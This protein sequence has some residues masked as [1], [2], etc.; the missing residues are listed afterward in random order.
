MVSFVR[1]NLSV[2]WD[3]RFATLLDFAKAC[4]V[5]VGFGCRNGTCHTCET[6]LLSGRISYITE[7]LEPP[8]ADRILVCSSQPRTEL[9]LDL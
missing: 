1:S 5:P 2:S 7:P 6:T 4:D 3:V 9:A 8:P